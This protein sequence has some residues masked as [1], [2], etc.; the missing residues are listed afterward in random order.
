MSLK[1]E[2]GT[3]ISLRRMRRSVFD[4]VR[5]TSGTLLLPLSQPDTGD[6]AEQA[7]C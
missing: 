3:N 4:I 2:K 5:D 6:M 7:I 1:M